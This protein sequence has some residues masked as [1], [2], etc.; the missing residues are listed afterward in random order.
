MDTAKP[1]RPRVSPIVSAIR[2]PQDGVLKRSYH[3]QLPQSKSL[4]YIDDPVIHPSPGNS[5]PGTAKPSPVQESFNLPQTGSNGNSGAASRSSTTPLKYSS[6]GKDLGLEGMQKV[7][8]ALLVPSQAVA[9]D[10]HHETSYDKARFGSTTMESS[11]GTD[12]LQL[13]TA[14]PGFTESQGTPAHLNQSTSSSTTNGVSSSTT[15]SGKSTKGSTT[16]NGTIG[17]ITPTRPEFTQSLSA[18]P[19]TGTEASGAAV[20]L[21]PG[22]TM[23]GKVSAGMAD[24]GG[25]SSGSGVPHAHAE[26]DEYYGG[27]EI[28]ARSRTYSNVSI[29]YPNRL[30]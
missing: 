2:V 6:G 3:I 11:D 7:G 22:G 29:P 18:G 5:Q 20:A 15:A 10:D 12:G 28:W 4:L 17:N 25:G 24:F 16:P 23:G 26:A 14:K 9:D 19:A 13:D 27:K 8:D 1:T 21:G 30:S